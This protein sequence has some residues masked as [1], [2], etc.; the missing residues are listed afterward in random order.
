[1]NRERPLVQ[2]KWRASAARWLFRAALLLTLAVEARAAEDFLDAVEQALSFASSDGQLRARFSGTVELEAYTFPGPAPWL[3]QS[4]EGTLVAP[5]LTAFL[6]A[7]W[8]PHVYAFVQARADRG[9]DPTDGDG[10]ARLDEYAVRVTPWL[11]SRLNVQLGKFATVVG[12]WAARHGSWTNAFIT[13]PMAYES[14]TGMWDTE[15][16]RF[17]T[18]LLQWSHVRPGLPAAVTAIEKSLRIPVIWG[19]SYAIGAA[20]SGELR[21]FQYAFEVKQGS[22]SSRPEAW[23]DMKGVWEHPTV[24]GRLGLRASEAWNFG[25]SASTGTYLR[26]LARPGIP[27][28]RGLG[29]YRQ[30]VLGH[31]I[32]YAHRH[33]QVWAEVFVSRFEIPVVGH[34]DMLS[35]YVEAKYKFTPQFFGAL[36]WNQQ[37]F[38]TIRERG[39]FREWGHEAWRID[40][41]PGYRF[42]AHTQLKFQYSVQRGDAP[43]RKL[44]HT[45]AGQF[46][47]RF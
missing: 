8:G 21:R 33:L 30:T 11:D 45:G 6:D 32:S 47:L 41:G 42:T 24:S 46:T 1:M 5:R 3:L 43:G 34:A 28:G 38:D 35:Y 31:D 18:V 25:V 12:S 39:R 23:D 29:D 15:A 9:F 2:T 20:V 36:R 19:P 26:L 27:A 14:L 13:A 17:S 44:A 22:L 37:L 10:E 4:D 16:I 7:Q 40:A